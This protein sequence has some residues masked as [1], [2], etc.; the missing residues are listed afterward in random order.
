MSVAFTATSGTV[1]N[2][3]TGTGLTGGPITTTGTISLADTAVVPGTYGAGVNYPS[4]TI[5]QQ[6]RITAA[7][8]VALGSAAA[9]T[10]GAAAGNVPVLD[11]NGLVPSVNG[12][13]STGDI[14]FNVGS[15]APTGWVFG[16]G[17]TIGSGAS[18]ATGRAN[19]D[20]VNLYTLLWNSWANAQAPVSGGRGANAAADFAANKTITVPDLR[21]TVLAGMDIMNGSGNAGRLS[22]VMAST[23]PGAGY[24][25]IG[26]NSA[27]TSIN[28]SGGNTINYGSVPWTQTLGQIITA[29]ELATI[30]S[31]SAPLA[32]L[33]D[34]VLVQGF[35][36]VNGTFGINV[37]GTGVSSNFV[38]AQSTMVMNVFVKL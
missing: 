10:A 2:I 7:T 18:G 24:S 23:T 9:L 19:A 34:Q 26:L 3:A 15:T 31:N 5:D 37:S 8:T 16:N 13:A 12:G 20:T 27:T 4:I 6:G 1:T 21:G 28:S 32:T 11:A 38:I 33:G 25:N 30:G 22:S 35:A 29:S 14:K 36:T 17:M